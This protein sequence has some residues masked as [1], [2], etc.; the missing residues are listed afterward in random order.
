[1][2][3]GDVDIHGVPH[4]LKAVRDEFR[5]Q[6][7]ARAETSPLHAFAGAAAVKIHFVVPALGHP[8]G[9]LRKFRGIASP[10]LAGNGMFTVVKGEQTLSVAVHQCGRRDHFRIKP[11]LPGKRQ[12]NIGAT[13]KRHRVSCVITFLI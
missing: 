13:Q 9:S 12:S 1:M 3:D 10:Q 11:R 8:F 5:F 7:E 4:R 2:L 6:H